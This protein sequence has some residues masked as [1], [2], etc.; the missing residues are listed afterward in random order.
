MSVAIL[1]KKDHIIN[2]VVT[3]DARPEPSKPPP[4]GST[5]ARWRAMAS[6]PSAHT[7]EPNQPQWARGEEYRQILAIG[8]TME[9]VLI[10][11]ARQALEVLEK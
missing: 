5:L 8:T 6:R 2:V 10:D 3:Y 9:E 1:V 4:E 7:A 11:F